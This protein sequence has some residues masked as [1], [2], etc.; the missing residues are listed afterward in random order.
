MTEIETD[1]HGK[2]IACH[3][4]TVPVSRSDVGGVVKGTCDNCDGWGLI[5]Q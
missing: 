1:Y 2:L 3:D 4:C 5:L